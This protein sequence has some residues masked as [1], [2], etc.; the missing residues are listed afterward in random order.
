MTEIQLNLTKKQKFIIFIIIFTFGH[1]HM[2]RFVVVVIFILISTFGQIH[3]ASFIVV[4]NLGQVHHANARR[5]QIF[6]HV[7]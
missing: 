6:G 2:A 7:H 4:V 1:I 5:F 3:M